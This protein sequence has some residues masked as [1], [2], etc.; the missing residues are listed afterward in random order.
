MFRGEALHVRTGKTVA[1]NG[2]LEATVSS[3]AR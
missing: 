1:V 2:G 3:A